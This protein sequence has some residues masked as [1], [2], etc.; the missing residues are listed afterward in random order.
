MTTLEGLAIRRHLDSMTAGKRVRLEKRM[1]R[2][3]RAKRNGNSDTCPFLS[4]EQ[5][6]DIYNIRPFSCRQL[7]SLRVCDSQGPLIYRQ[8]VELARQTVTRLQHLDDTGYSGHISF[9]LELLKQKSFCR[10][11]LSGGFDPQRV[12][13]YGKRNGI[14]IN[15]WVSA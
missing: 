3:R 10:R 7:Y 14:L 15:R 8:A 5:Q 12:A 1:E 2:N 4:E 6:C 11:Y 9:I 13:D